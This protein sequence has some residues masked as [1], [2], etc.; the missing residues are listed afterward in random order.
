MQE[1]ELKPAT[2]IRQ[3]N[4]R[5]AMVMDEVQDKVPFATWDPDTT[6]PE[7]NPYRDLIKP[8][9]VTLKPGDMLYLPA[10]W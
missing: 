2:Y 3:E 1:Q 8:M 5:L 6:L 4:G 10:M 7:S 9:R